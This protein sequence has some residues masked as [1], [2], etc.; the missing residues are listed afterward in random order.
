[1]QSTILIPEPE[2]DPDPDPKTS[3]SPPSPYLTQP[4]TLQI[5]SVSHSL[6]RSD[7][8]RRWNPDPKHRPSPERAAGGPSPATL[9]ATR[10]CAATASSPAATAP[11]P[12]TAIMCAPTPTGRLLP[13]SRTSRTS[14]TVGRGTRARRRGGRG[15]GAALRRTL[16][17]PRRQYRL[18]VFSRTLPR[19]RP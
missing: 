15:D 7:G 12:R 8:L 14:R 1:M 6:L 19:C 10:S 2:S 3:S 18:A 9:A 13:P 11:A 16:T 17:R 4:S 5:P